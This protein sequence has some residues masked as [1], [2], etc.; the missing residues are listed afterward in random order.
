MGGIAIVKVRS[1]VEFTPDAAAA[2][3]RAE[4]QCRRSSVATS[5]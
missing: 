4:A 3:R 1:G 2:F 5:T